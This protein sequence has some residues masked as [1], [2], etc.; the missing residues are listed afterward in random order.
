MGTENQA[1]QLSHLQLTPD[2]SGQGLVVLLGFIVI[3]KL[4]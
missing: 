3:C 2:N 1:Y 4:W